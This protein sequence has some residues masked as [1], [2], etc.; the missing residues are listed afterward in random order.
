MLWRVSQRINL[1]SN[2]GAFWL[3]GGRVLK[4]V[5]NLAWGPLASPACATV[6]LVM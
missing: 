6:G 5:Q 4:G 3:W 1:L 2:S